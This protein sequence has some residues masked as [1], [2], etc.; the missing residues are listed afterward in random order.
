MFVHPVTAMFLLA[1]AIALA[2]GG[3]LLG[4][5][6]GAERA[7][8]A[9]TVD[10]AEAAL[11]TALVT[12]KVQE[13]MRDRVLRLARN[14]TRRRFILLSEQGPTA[15]DEKVSY[16]SLASAGVD[17]ALEV[18]V[19]SFGLEGRWSINPEVAL[20]MTLRTRLVRVGDGTLIYEATFE[21]KGEARTFAEWAANNAQPFRDALEAAYQS[22]AQRVVWE[23]F[24]RKGDP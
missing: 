15:L 10:E 1:S 13:A 16:Q 22:L 18:S 23:L 17:S 3:A 20:F 5:L 12:L 9:A 8:P 7:E 19:V 6:A 21:H 11:K 4:G 24:L 14:Q 2:S